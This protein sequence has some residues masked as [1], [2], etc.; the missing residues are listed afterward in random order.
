MQNIAFIHY[1]YEFYVFILAYVTVRTMG[2][3]AP[4]RR[5]QLCLILAVSLFLGKLCITI[6]FYNSHIN[7]MV[8]GFPQCWQ[9]QQSFQCI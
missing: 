3:I 1:I 9:M 2:S 7:S 6:H 4:H 5:Y 8:N